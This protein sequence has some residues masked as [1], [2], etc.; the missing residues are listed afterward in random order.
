MKIIKLIIKGY[1]RT[2]AISN[3]DKIIYTPRKKVQLIGG[4]NGSG[5]SSLL[6]LML[7]FPPNIK[8]DFNEGG[9]VK[10]K[11]THRGINYNISSGVDGPLR[12]TFNKD[13]KE[14]NPGGTRK[15]QVK[16]LEEHFKL[17]K[18]MYDILLNKKTLTGMNAKERK[19]LFTVISP[20]NYDYPYSV[21]NRIRTELRDLQGGIKIQAKRVI[22]LEASIESVEYIEELKHNVE[23]MKSDITNLKEKIKDVTLENIEELTAK[24]DNDVNKLE[25]IT[26]SIKSNKELTEIDRNIII[27]KLGTAK[28]NIK[29]LRDKDINLTNIKRLETIKSEIVKTEDNIRTAQSNGDAL[30]LNKGHGKHYE[31]FCVSMAAIT[32]ILTD[33]DNIDIDRYTNELDNNIKLYSD[34]T[35]KADDIVNKNRNA[36]ASLE[37][38]LNASKSDDV[39]CVKCGHTWKD[40]YNKD[41]KDSLIAKI[42]KYERMLASLKD[43]TNALKNKI[44]KMSTVIEKRE[45]IITELKRS[46]IGDMIINRVK[47]VI[48]SD[49]IDIINE[50]IDALKYMDSLS[51]LEHSLS[52]LNREY[53][54]LELKSKL[55]GDDISKD[56]LSMKIQ[57]EEQV[58]SELN[59]I[60]DSDKKRKKDIRNGINIFNNIL[61]LNK[62]IRK[63]NA[64]H[65]TNINNQFLNECISYLETEV[66]AAQEILN[67]NKTASTLY[68]DRLKEIQN[69]K[70]RVVILKDALN[71]L[72][73]TNGL[74]AETIM[75]FLGAFGRNM[76][77]IIRDIW[78]YKLEIKPPPLLTDSDLEYTFPIGLPN[79]EMS[80]VCSVSSGMA[81]VINLAFKLVYM[82]LM[83]IDDYPLLL[84]EYGARFDVKHKSNAVSMIDKLSM[85]YDN[86]YIITHDASMF[87]IYKDADINLL[88]FDN[89]GTVISSGRINE[90]FKIN[91][92]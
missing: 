39:T 19:E 60:L 40:G 58:C 38:Q 79:G 13:G 3:I 21:Y 1:K 61:R 53:E 87:G 12:H 18:D 14:L 67:N 27:Y 83:D 34:L 70:D 36:K 32:P 29:K 6:E 91:I 52:S 28:D 82:K 25:T 71:V 2:A 85:S 35:S 37:F 24:R 7:P 89:V 30:G 66:I 8:R 49:M 59:N 47:N 57:N 76:T 5:K 73:P 23:E 69:D 42:N 81:E 72:S 22:E 92:K 48:S 31:S 41:I 15:V 4:M 16:L 33:M 84:D 90:N 9:Y 45:T 65:V 88:T 50:Y 80:D 86:L 10:W 78:S 51:N 64:N 55:S 44:R 20:V 11:I 62:K 56:S 54:I 26:E 63:A 74:I 43:E 75:S 46:P 17:T 77:D 68:S